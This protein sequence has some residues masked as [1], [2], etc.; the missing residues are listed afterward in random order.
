M[1][2]HL[3]FEKLIQDVYDEVDRRETDTSWL[4]SQQD[5]ALVNERYIVPFL[6]VSYLLLLC[7]YCSKVCDEQCCTNNVLLLLRGFYLLFLRIVIYYISFIFLFDSG[8]ENDVF[9]VYKIYI[10]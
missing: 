6:P 5:G 4:A 7:R 10:V 2:P 9:G 8:S 1:L 3:V